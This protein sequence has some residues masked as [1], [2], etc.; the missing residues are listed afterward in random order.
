MY[1]TQVT[2]V[3]NLLTDVGERRL[4]NGTVVANFRVASKE[5]RFDRAGGTWVDGDRLFIDVRCWRDLAQNALESLNKGDPV[6][7]TGRIF[8]RNYEHQGQRRTSTTLE[9]RSV[10]A[11]LAHCTVVLT[12]TRRGVTDAYPGHDDRA[13]TGGVD[14]REVDG[15]EWEQHGDAPEVEAGSQSARR[16]DG[17]RPHLVGA[18]PGDE[19]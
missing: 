7:V 16:P 2:V 18:A 15:S 9:A 5:R 10:A 13:D 8:T 19:G 1:E 6:V 4:N 3:G 14:G 11:D 12:R 17:F